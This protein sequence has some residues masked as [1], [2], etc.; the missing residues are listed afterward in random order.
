MT[1]WI[2]RWTEAARAAGDTMRPLLTF[3]ITACFNLTLT[4]AVLTRRLQV[5]EYIAAV[6]P[7]NSMI[8]GFWFA[9][10]RAILSDNTRHSGGSNA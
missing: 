4:W 7:M 3:F 10:K 1:D 9:E 6:G 5:G 8:L 2:K